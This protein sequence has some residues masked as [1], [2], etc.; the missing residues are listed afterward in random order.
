MSWN[1]VDKVY[2][3]GDFNIFLCGFQSQEEKKIVLLAS[4]W[5]IKGALVVLKEWSPKQSFDEIDFLESLFQVQIHNLLLGRMNPQNVERIGNFVRKFIC[6][7][8]KN[9]NQFWK[10]FLHV[11]ISIKLS[12]SLK[13]RFFLEKE[14][15]SHIWIQF[16][17][18]H[19]LDICF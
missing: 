13:I 8:A 1:L 14:D 9:T 17:Y 10:K 6:G 7:D 16:C 4:S 15:G 11:R 5:S 3:F 19:L 2:I 12:S 18:E